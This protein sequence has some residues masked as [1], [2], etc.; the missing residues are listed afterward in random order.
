MGPGGALRSRWES[1][2]LTAQD[3]LMGV[4][5]AVPTSTVLG[6]AAWLSPAAE[7]VG[8]H[9]QLGLSGC[10]VLTATGW[11]C[12]MCGMTTTFAHMAHLSPIEALRTQPFGVA[13]FLATLSLASVGWADLLL[14]GGRWRRLWAWALAREVPLAVLTLLGMAVGWAYKVMIIKEMI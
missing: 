2:G 5:L 13:L 14:G 9:M 6:V 4:V 3:R 1:L 10:S 7:G 8:T 11:P 12:P